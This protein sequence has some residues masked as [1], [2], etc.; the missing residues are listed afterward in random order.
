M[1]R[2]PHR[3]PCCV[4]LLAAALLFAAGPARAATINYGSYTSPA[5]D[6]EFNDVSDT[7]K[8]QIPAELV[9]DPDGLYGAPLAADIDINRLTFNNI[10]ADYAATAYPVDSASYNIL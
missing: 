10:S 5:S 3:S 9:T 8:A 6:F 4:S 1:S 2:N 7:T